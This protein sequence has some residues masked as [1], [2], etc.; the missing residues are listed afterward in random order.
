M[1]DNTIRK[2]IRRDEKMVIRTNEE[3]YITAYS[4][5]NG[6]IEGMKYEGEVPEGFY[7]CM[8]TYKLIEGQLVLDE[9]K[10]AQL[11]NSNH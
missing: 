1:G 11:R 6:H 9:E 5:G 10:K 3:G 4:V 8:G 2:S 7:E